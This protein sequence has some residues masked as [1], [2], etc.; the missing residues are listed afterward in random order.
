MKRIAISLCGEGRGH[1]T[2]IA[3]LVEHLAVEH[4]IV[5]FTSADALAFLRRR[6]P[7]GAGRVDVREIPGLVFQYTGGRLDLMR[8]VTSGIDYQAR[9]LGPLV[10]RL[11]GEL[12]AFDADL[13]I[14][15]FEPALPRACARQGIPLVSVDHQHF[16]LA[17]DLGALPRSLQWHAWLMGHAVWMCT[18]GATE[19]VVSA[20]FRPPLKRGWEHVIQVGQIG[21]A[22]V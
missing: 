12:D 13:G 21:R 15:D 9:V 7:P 3:T 1:A 16:L 20:F 14:T 22:H 6:F 10:E 8:S 11:I 5:V 18:F 4:E 17:Y 2:R 19:T